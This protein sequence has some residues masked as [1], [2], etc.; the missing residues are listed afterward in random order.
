MSISVIF[1]ELAVFLGYLSLPKYTFKEGKDMFFA[2]MF[3]AFHATLSLSALHGM[4]IPMYGAIKR[5]TPL[6]NLILSVVV[7]KKGMPSR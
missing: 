2:S 7:L 5:C 1:L 4:N 6:V 3:F